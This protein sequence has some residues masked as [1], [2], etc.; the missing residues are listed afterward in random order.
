MTSPR[1]HGLTTIYFRHTENRPRRLHQFRPDPRFRH[2]QRQSRW[3][4]PH[5]SSLGPAIDCKPRS[6]LTKEL[7]YRNGNPST[8]GGLEVIRQVAS[9][10]NIATGDMQDG[11]ELSSGNRTPACNQVDLL[12]KMAS[13]L[14][15]PSCR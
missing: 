10:L 3:P 14:R 1:S 9:E 13:R 15:T 11:S 5:C 6:M 12:S 7:G 8:N 4:P 2:H